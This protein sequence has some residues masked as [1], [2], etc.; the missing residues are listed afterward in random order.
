MKKLIAVFLA[1]LL[2]AGLCLP[3]AAETPAEQA[4]LRFKTTERSVF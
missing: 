3:A 4:K 1:L 2:V